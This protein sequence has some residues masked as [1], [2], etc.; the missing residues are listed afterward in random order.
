MPCLLRVRR[1]AIVSACAG[2]ATLTLDPK[3]L[4]VVGMAVV[5]MHDKKNCRLLGFDVLRWRTLI[6]RLRLACQRHVR[7]LDSSGLTNV[8]P[9]K[10]T[11]A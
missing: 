7:V 6:L 9:G 5:G 1:N 10:M 11:G 3:F 4:A 2:S 8:L